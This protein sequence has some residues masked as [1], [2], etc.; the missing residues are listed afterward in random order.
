M[1]QGGEDRSGR[2]RFAGVCSS[3]ALSLAPLPGSETSP[4]GAYDR[5]GRLTRNDSPERRR[6]QT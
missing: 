5:N 4:S 2:R 6:R 3:G 1:W